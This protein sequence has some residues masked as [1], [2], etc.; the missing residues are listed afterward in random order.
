MDSSTIRNESIIH[1][2]N[3]GC[4]VYINSVFDRKSY[5]VYANS[6]DHDQMHILLGLHCL[7]RSHSWVK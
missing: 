4:A 3:V 1:F 6:V 7:P 5:S 2:Q